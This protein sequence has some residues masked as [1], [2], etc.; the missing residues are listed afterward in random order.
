M[1]KEISHVATSWA[2]ASIDKLS[3]TASIELS[4][5]S[6]AGG[7]VGRMR[8]GSIKGTR[9]TGHEEKLVT[10]SG[11]VV[12]SFTNAGGIVG[13]AIRDGSYSNITIENAEVESSSIYG[14]GIINGSI[15]AETE[16]SNVR[17]SVDW[18]NSPYD[19]EG[20]NKDSSFAG[21][22]INSTNIKGDILLDLAGT[23]SA[24]LKLS[25]VGLGVSSSGGIVGYASSTI[26][27]THDP[28]VA[29]NCNYPI[30]INNCNI[31]ASYVGFATSTFSGG[32]VGIAS[33]RKYS[34]EKNYSILIKDCISNA[35][36]SGFI[37]L[38]Y[39]GGIVG[40][41]NN[42]TIWNC[43]YTGSKIVESFYEDLMNNHS[44]SDWLG[45]A[46]ALLN[47]LSVPY[48]MGGITGYM[49]S[50]YVRNCS[51][52]DWGSIDGIVSMSIG[53][54]VAGGII[55][56]MAGGLLGAD[57]LSFIVNSSLVWAVSGVSGGIVG[58]MN[59]GA[60]ETSNYTPLSILTDLIG[61]ISGNSADVTSASSLPL[62]SNFKGFMINSPSAFVIGNISGGIIGLYNSGKNDVTGAI[63][64]GTVSTS[65]FFALSGSKTVSTFLVK[66]T[67]K[68]AS[69]TGWIGNLINGT[70]EDV[71]NIEKMLKILRRNLKNM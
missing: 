64:L 54:R 15:T 14:I 56:V 21:I 59:G 48:V 69:L 70:E 50:G 58:V 36:I 1:F 44:I 40:Y 63:N 65:L 35:D 9:E 60:F 46:G 2:S 25:G 68:L 42:A 4:G 7:I 22:N 37:L 31:D 62:G 11:A 28:N 3:N 53:Y 19:A 13:E 16:L 23:L 24:N 12:I 41:L 51:A 6:V 55:G 20:E 38:S 45:S 30:Y 10:T 17:G 5:Y 71:K 26:S 27:G 33:G 61:S 66:A 18:T 47:A 57:T 43:T 34:T 39:G 32:I 29:A 52:G 67:D 8:G 49:E